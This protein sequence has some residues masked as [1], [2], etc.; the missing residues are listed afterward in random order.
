[1]LLRSAPELH[2][3]ITVTALLKDPDDPVEKADILF[4]Y[5]YESGVTEGNKYG[6][7]LTVVKKFPASVESPISGTVTDWKI[8]VG[9]VISDRG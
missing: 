9:D 1:M 4:E 2:Y 3:P 8:K 5:T 7:T 6:D